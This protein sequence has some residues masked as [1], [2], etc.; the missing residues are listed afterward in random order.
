MI[1]R[2]R[3]TDKD[4]DQL[5]GINIDAS[6]LEDDF[7]DY[8]NVVIKKP[9]GQEYLIFRNDNIAIWIL[10]IKQGCQTSMH[11]HPNKKTSLAVLSGEVRFCTLDI[12]ETIIAGEGRLIEKGVFH[13]SE[14]LS[15]EGVLIME[16]ETPTN[17]KDLIRL[18]DEYGRSGKGYEGTS[19]HIPVGDL[20][21]FHGDNDRYH[22]DKSFG[23][24]SLTVIRHEEGGDMDEKLK[25]L[26]PSV[27]AVLHGDLKDDSGEIIMEVGDV[28]SWEYLKE[29]GA[30]LPSEGAEVLAIKKT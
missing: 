12:E 1:K 6:L 10:H 14:A 21:H 13:S 30:L 19:N 8:T 27:V 20:P 5:E 4:R 9:W 16:T 22:T 15:E 7:F 29:V 3:L 25:T 28:A 26:H 11:C 17:K 18:K 23:E 2:L 24:C